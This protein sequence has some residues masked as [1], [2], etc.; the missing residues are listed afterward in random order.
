MVRRRDFRNF[1]LRA[2]T[3]FWDR[4]ARWNAQRH[5]NKPGRGFEMQEEQQ[6][7]IYLCRCSFEAHL[8]LTH[9]FCF[10]ST[11]SPEEIARTIRC[12]IPG[13]EEKTQHDMLV[14]NFWNHCRAV[15]GI[16]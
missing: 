8:K 14:Y 4:I 10:C 15:G 7:N 13:P 16:L 1:V 5:M 11:A 12:A 2:L 3:T 9:L 6:R